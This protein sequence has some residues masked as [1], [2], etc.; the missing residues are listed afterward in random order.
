MLIYLSSALNVRLHASMPS[1][2]RC[3]TF[4]LPPPPQFLNQ[5]PPGAQQL[6]L[7]D[8]SNVPHFGHTNI[9]V[10]VKANAG[11][12]TGV[13]VNVLDIS[14]RSVIV[15]RLVFQRLV[16]GLGDIYSGAVPGIVQ[17]LVIGL[18]DIY[19]GA[20]AGIVQRLVI[21]RCDIYCGAVA[22]LVTEVHSVRGIEPDDPENIW[23]L[24][25]FE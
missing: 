20:V 2:Q 14:S 23:F 7:P 15:Q 17:R 9:S 3:S 25:A 8:F 5:A 19:C 13:L 18:G 22:E 21:G 24:L 12:L 1:I 6:A 4:P 11:V 16:I 10:I